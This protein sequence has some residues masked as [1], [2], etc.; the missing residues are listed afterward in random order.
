[1]FARCAAAARAPFPLAGGRAFATD[2]TLR[3][4]PFGASADAL[5]AMLKGL[6]TTPPSK[7]CP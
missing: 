4:L 7:V 3:N 1:M 5:E 2:V 6:G